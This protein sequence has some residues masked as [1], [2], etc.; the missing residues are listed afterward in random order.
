MPLPRNREKESEK[1]REREKLLC[2]R[3]QH[4]ASYT[5]SINTIIMIL[6]KIT[7][8]SSSSVVCP[9]VWIVAA[10]H[11]STR[12]S[13]IIRFLYRF[14]SLSR[15]VVILSPFH[16]LIADIFDRKDNCPY[17]SLDC[18]AYSTHWFDQLNQPII[19][20]CFN[21]HTINTRRYPL[22]C[23]HSY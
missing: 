2:Y 21:R 22:L 12:H 17:L 8:C 23:S 20:S 7:L 18:L 9:S 19:S 5:Q 14:L 3:R 6:R 13:T 4:V 11:Y 10:C 16:F 1:R 15:S